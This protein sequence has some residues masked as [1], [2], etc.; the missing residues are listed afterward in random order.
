MQTRLKIDIHQIL[1][2]VSIALISA[3]IMASSS[4]REKVKVLEATVPT[5]QEVTL[6]IKELDQK[7]EYRLDKIEQNQKLILHL[8]KVENS[9]K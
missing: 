8:L 7:L 2:G 9:K 5:R 4:N 6:G 1:T 3:F